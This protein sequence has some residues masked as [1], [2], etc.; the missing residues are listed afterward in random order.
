MFRTPEGW[1]RREG[2]EAFILE[3]SENG[4]LRVWM[5]HAPIARVKELAA[6]R[7][8]ALD[9][10]VVEE[11]G[12]PR[13]LSLASGAAA[14]E[15]VST[16]S[17]RGVSASALLVFVVLPDE[18][19]VVGGVS[20]RE[21]SA[22]SSSAAREIVESFEL[23]DA[24]LRFLYAPPREWHGRAQ[25]EATMWYAPTFPRMRATLTV[26]PAERRPPHGLVSHVY[27]AIVAT[28]ERNGFMRE[29][30]DGPHAIA[31]DFGLSGMAWS[32]VGQSR[33]AQRLCRDIV[34][35]ADEGYV[36]TFILATLTPRDRDA[37]LPE[38]RAMIN[39]ARPAR[40]FSELL[41]A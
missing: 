37:L 17:C 14:C 7:W 31:S 9:D 4:S 23:G 11:Q 6:E 24:T 36:Y 3:H 27:D 40:G 2:G 15:I 34:V 8:H 22:Q 26:S 41:L 39:S 29:R 1:T 10:Y 25:H 32:I 21:R 12:A 13:L 18:I 33:G 35:L 28:D 19:V 20:P 38:F 30:A 16:G 5:R